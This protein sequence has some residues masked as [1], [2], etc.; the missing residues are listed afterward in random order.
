MRSYVPSLSLVL[1]G[2]AAATTGCSFPTKPGPPFAC[3]GEKLPITAPDTIQ[4]RGTV[5]DPFQNAPVVGASVTAYVTD[6]GTTGPTKTFMK[7]TDAT[8]IFIGSQMTLGTPHT[9][10]ITSEAAGYLETIAYPA[11]PIAD[12]VNV[13]LQ[14]F[15][16]TNIQG[17]MGCE[18][19]QTMP[20]ASICAHCGPDENYLIAA[21]V[22]CNDAAVGGATVTIPGQNGYLVGYLN[23]KGLSFSAS[24]TDPATGAALVVGLTGTVT[25]HAT[26]GSTPYRDNKVTLTPGAMTFAEISP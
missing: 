9:E 2:A 16:Q 5:V 14:Q 12:D 6:T 7:T 20:S 8:G 11:V 22:D 25:I 23:S 19:C 3:V 24:A 17:L 1:A 26:L 18:V 13:E 10:Y 21:V 15:V 4:V